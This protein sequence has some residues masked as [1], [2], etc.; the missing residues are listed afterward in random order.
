MTSLHPIISRCVRPGT[1]VHS[2]D[3]ASHRQMDRRIN[4]VSAHQIVVHRLNF[5]NS[6]TGVHTQGI[7][8]CWNTLKLGQKTH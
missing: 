1:E 6:V 5:V 8:S 3:W 2:D 7:K 4:N